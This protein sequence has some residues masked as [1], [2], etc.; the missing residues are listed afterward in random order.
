MQLDWLHLCWQSTILFHYTISTGIHSDYYMLCNGQIFTNKMKARDIY[1]ELFDYKCVNQLS[2][3]KLRRQV[4][5][6]NHSE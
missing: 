3:A 6:M 2:A 5:M 4:D 1:L